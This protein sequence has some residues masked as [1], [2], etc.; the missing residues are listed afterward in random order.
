MVEP[1]LPL[2]HL[3]Y[4]EVIQGLMLSDAYITNPKPNKGNARIEITQTP[5]R[6]EFLYHL[7]EY[8]LDVGLSCNIRQILHY[9]K[10]AK[11]YYVTCHLATSKNPTITEM[12]KIWY[13]DNKLKVV[14][15]NLKLT[16]K[17]LAYWMFGDG[18]TRY[19]NRGNSIDIQLSTN[20]FIKSDVLFLQ[21]Q[22]KRLNL[23]LGLWHKYKKYWI[24]RGTEYKMTERFMNL[25]EPYIIP[26]F[27][28]KIKH[29][30]R[31]EIKN[32]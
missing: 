32:C 2:H 24:L 13:S 25:I 10:Q 18:Y 3:P 20:A 11:K 5:K 6:I 8:F 14:P 22:L 30:P 7:S 9:N 29:L 17:I 21:N 15:K 26:C 16:P 23:E 27:Q 19:I 31:F 12:R 4:D 28:Y 1:H